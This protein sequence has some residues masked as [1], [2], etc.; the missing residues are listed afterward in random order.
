MLLFISEVPV[1]IFGT[2]TNSLPEM[3]G[4]FA[5]FHTSSKKTGIIYQNNI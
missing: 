4:F 3:T 1:S 2:D 5:V